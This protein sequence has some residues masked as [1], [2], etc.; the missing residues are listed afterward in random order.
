LFP[1]S[2]TILFCNSI[3]FVKPNVIL[4]NI[5][6]SMKSEIKNLSKSDVVV[7]CGGTQDVGRDTT[8]KGLS[9]VLQ[10]VKNSEHT[11]VIIKGIL[12]RFDLGDSSCVNPL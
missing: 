6:S 9:S 11:N 12:H 4:N 1:N 7:L 5:T 3:G 8:M 10:F 2:Y